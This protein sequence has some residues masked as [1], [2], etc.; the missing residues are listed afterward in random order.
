MKTSLPHSVR[1]K[2]QAVHA[3]ILDPTVCAGTR[4][5]AS[6][7]DAERPTRRCDAERRNEGQPPLTGGFGLPPSAVGLPYAA[8]RLCL[9]LLLIPCLAAAARAQSSALPAA[10]ERP[11]NT[12][13]EERAE[14]RRELER[15]AQAL[16][17]QSAVVKIVAKLVG[18]SV[19]HI[20]TDVPPDADAPDGRGRHLEEVGSGVIIERKDHYYVLTSRHVIRSAASTAIRIYLADGRLLHPKKVWEDPDTD[21]AVMA[22]SAPDLVA[23]PLGDSDRMEIGD[24]VLAVGSPFGLS[25]SITFGIISAKGRRD[26]R[27]NDA[28]VR[29]QDFLQT[30]A[31]IN[32][33]NSGG[34]LVNLRG[35]I[36]G[37]NDAI[38]SRTGKN[39]GIGFAIPSNMFMIVGRQLIE[40]GKVAHA[41][42]GVNLN[43]KF[44]PAMASELGLPRPIGAHVTS[45][46]PN[47][48]AEAAKLQVGDVLLEFNHTPIENDAHLVNLVSLTP[49]GTTV[50]LLIFRDRK[51]MT[52]MVEVGDRSKFERPQPI[53]G[54]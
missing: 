24:F 20:E 4:R 3:A 10:L 17:E 7:R 5:V 48:P 8:F 12:R 53:S 2:S 50:P 51:T 37:I 1:N 22:V 38:A 47:S 44:G 36:I 41:F 21:V 18:P 45:V 14:L 35:E 31:A 15:H 42:L 19:V 33:G 28:T 27:L 23:A 13:P 9:V 25:N 52:V 29:F 40:T 32:P 54:E 46:T 6:L 11:T 34:P 49:V 39:E 30:D 16:E 26:L 43:S